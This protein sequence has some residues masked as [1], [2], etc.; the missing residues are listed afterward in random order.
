MDYR[1][2]KKGLADIAEK[3]KVT[4]HEVRPKDVVVS[5]W[6]RWKCQYGCKGY[7]RHLSCPPY[8]PGPEQTRKLLSEYHKAY[9]IRF[10]GLP[11]MKDA[12]LGSLPKNWHHF[13]KGLILWI[14]ETIYEMEQH[15]FY[16]EYYKALGFAAYPCIFCDDCV[17]EQMQGTVDL[18]VKRLCPHGEKV[19]PSMEAAGID[20][21]ATVRKAGLPVSVVPCKNNEY[22]MIMTTDINSY[23]L[24][25]I[26]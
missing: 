4:I 9:L 2:L 11:G 24:L 26:E 6:V 12:D 18:S 23:G 20:V 1:R 25:L 3:N 13:L 7:A 16:Q 21:F 14:H 8:V 19:R 15:A 17:A 22:G 5:E 10:A